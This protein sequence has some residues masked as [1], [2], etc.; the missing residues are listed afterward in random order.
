[1]HSRAYLETVVRGS[2]THPINRGKANPVQLTA[3]D[4]SRVEIEML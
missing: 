4:R 1:M 2:S 3:T